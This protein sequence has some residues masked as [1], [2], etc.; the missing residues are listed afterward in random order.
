MQVAE[1]QSWSFHANFHLADFQQVKLLMHDEGQKN[2]WPLNMFNR[3]RK[4]SVL[5]LLTNV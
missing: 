3:N 5:T 4:S 1:Y 2:K